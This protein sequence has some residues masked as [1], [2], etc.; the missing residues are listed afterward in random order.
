MNALRYLK[1]G[2]QQY[3]SRLFSVVPSDR[4]RSNRP[5]MK[6]KKT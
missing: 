6:Y 5:K 4:T 1:G 3:K 2:C